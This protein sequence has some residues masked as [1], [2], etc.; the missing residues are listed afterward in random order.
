MPK[1]AI[2]K[3]KQRALRTE[4]EILAALV[5][6]VTRENE[7]VT[8]VQVEDLYYPLLIASSAEECNWSLSDLAKHQIR[9]YPKAIIG[10]IHSHPNTETI[11]ISPDDLKSAAELQEIVFGVLTWWKPEGQRRETSLDF[12]CQGKAIKYQ[13][14]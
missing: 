6:T 14:L 4:N 7:R 11:H 9:I 13:L 8:R 10:S 5:G 1:A 3:F 12:Y 2:A